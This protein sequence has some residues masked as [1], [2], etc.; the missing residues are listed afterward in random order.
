M[1]RVFL[2]HCSVDK[3]IVRRIADDLAHLGHRPWLDEWE[4]KVG[5][6]IITRVEHGIENAD[7]VVLVLSPSAVSSGWVDRE[8]KQKYWQEIEKRT[9]ML[10]PVLVA[11]CNIPPLLRSRKYAD[12]RQNYAVALVQLA[13]AIAPVIE[14]VEAESVESTPCTS[15]VTDLIQQLHGRQKPLSQMIAEA[16]TIAQEAG[17]SR[18][19][20]WCRLELTGWDQQST[21]DGS[22]DLSY[23]EVSVFLALKGEINLMYEGWSENLANALEYMR[24]NSDQFQALRMRITYPVSRLEG[25]DPPNHPA[26]SLTTFTIPRRSLFPETKNPDTP[27]VV[28]APGDAIPGVL[29]SVRT[30][31]TR[32]LLGLLPKVTLAGE[33]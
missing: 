13:S 22:Y 21:K 7:Y 10:L 1:S 20:N 33:A 32:H 5:E 11:D 28:Y 31:L 15:K 12:F 30:E 18:F 14:T 24:R 26:K 25:K 3:E 27:L 16:L 19:E 29:E 17:N 8:W 9:V 2:S 23:R 4:I 6:C